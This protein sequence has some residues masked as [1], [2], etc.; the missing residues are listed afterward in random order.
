[1]KYLVDSDALSD[2]YDSGSS[3]HP[4]MTARLASL[5]DSDEVFISILAIYELE[6]GFARAPRTGPPLPGTQMTGQR[7]GAEES[8]RLFRSFPNQTTR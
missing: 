6:Y 7:V 5:S 4:A 3:G 8:A 1:M 2:L